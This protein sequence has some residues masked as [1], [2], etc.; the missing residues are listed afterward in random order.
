[1]GRRHKRELPNSL[2]KLPNSSGELPNSPREL[3]NSPVDSGEGQKV[4][5]RLRKTASKSVE[6][7]DKGSWRLFHWERT[8]SFWRAQQPR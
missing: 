4:S 6:A 3:G 5:R 7:I 1:M 2:P 8:A